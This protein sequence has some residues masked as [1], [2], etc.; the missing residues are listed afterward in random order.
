MSRESRWEKPTT[1]KKEHEQKHEVIERDGAR[2]RA[3]NF[4]LFWDVQ[5][6]ELKVEPPAKKHPAGRRQL[7]DVW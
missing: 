6:A 1:Q 5:G 2:S 4:S 7:E 3:G